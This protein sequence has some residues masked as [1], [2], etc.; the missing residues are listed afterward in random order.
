M[1]IQ[2]LICEV[3][4]LLLDWLREFGCRLAQGADCVIFYVLRCFC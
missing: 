1:G 3:V 2:L 4:F